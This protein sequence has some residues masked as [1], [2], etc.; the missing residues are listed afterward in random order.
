MEINIID[1]Q[2]SSHENVVTEPEDTAHYSGDTWTPLDEGK[3][4]QIKA[5]WSIKRTTHWNPFF[6]SLLLLGRTEINSRG[7]TWT[8]RSRNWNASTLAESWKV[9]CRRWPGAL[10]WIRC[11]VRRQIQVR[12]IASLANSQCALINSC[13][14]SSN[15]NGK[16][17]IKWMGGRGGSG[18]R[19]ED[20]RLIG[21]HLRAPRPVRWHG[22]V[23]GHFARF[24]APLTVAGTY[25]QRTLNYKLVQLKIP[26]VQLYDRI[27]CT[28]MSPS[29][30]PPGDAVS[31]CRD[32]VDAIHLAT[33]HKLGREKA[34]LL[35]LLSLPHIQVSVILI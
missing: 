29:R 32:A 35:Q 30:A 1:R 7:S 19:A 16:W 24:T 9:L 8:T 11:T 18:S 2:R 13:G 5:N 33:G 28:V 23:A 17:I 4:K 25:F 14:F 15:W 22:S 10:P 27:S 31:R 26:C 21:R 6:L 34:E 20:Y 12:L 3:R